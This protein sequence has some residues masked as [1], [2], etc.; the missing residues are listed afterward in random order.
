MAWWDVF[1][2]NLLPREIPVHPYCVRPTLIYIDG[3]E[4]DGTND[5]RVSSIGAVIDSPRIDHL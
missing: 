1:D 4:C 5:E 2:E 3:A